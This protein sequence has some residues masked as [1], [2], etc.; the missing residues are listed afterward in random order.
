MPTDIRNLPAVSLPVSDET[1]QGMLRQVAEIMFMA[2][3]VTT[4]IVGFAVFCVGHDDSAT[5]ETKTASRGDVTVYCA[6]PGLCIDSI[7]P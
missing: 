7:A 6:E 5:G 4:I 1:D 2:L 3:F